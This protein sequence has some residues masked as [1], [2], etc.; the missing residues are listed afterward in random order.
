M[1]RA[2]LGRAPP[3]ADGDALGVALPVVERQLE[4]AD[5]AIQG[6]NLEER[7]VGLRNEGL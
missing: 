4:L 6:T 5:D 3:A 2:G 7:G 1:A